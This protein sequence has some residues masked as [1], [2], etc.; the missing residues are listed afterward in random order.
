MENCETSSLGRALANFG[1][2]GSEFSSADEL[3]NAIINQ[4]DSIKEQIKKQ[5]TETKSTKLFTDWKNENDLIE[6]LFE[7]QEK[8]IKTTGGTNAKQW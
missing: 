5:T 8:S 4:N 1:L 7:Q 6:K 3:A 2:H